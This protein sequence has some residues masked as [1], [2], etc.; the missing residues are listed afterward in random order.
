VIYAHA[1]WEALS[2]ISNPSVQLKSLLADLDT[3]TLLFR[4]AKEAF[5]V[6]EVPGSRQMRKK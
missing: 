5:D 4:W 6:N 2:K 1:L 3:E